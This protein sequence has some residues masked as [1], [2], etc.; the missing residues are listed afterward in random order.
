MIAIRHLVAGCV[1]LLV[2]GA[3]TGCASPASPTGLPADAS[4]VPTPTV[5]STT[6]LHLP[7]EAYMLTPT[8]SVRRD[9]VESVAVSA[10]MRRFGFRVPAGVMPGHGGN[11]G[12]SYSVMYRRYGVT[13]ADS[14]RVWGYHLP[15]P[16]ANGAG[17]GATRK[18]HLP[19]AERAV[20]TGT[21]PKGKAITRYAGRPV[22]SN[23]CLGEGDAVVG[24]TGS[25]VQG[26][27][28]GP[29]GIVAKLKRDSFSRSQIDHR[30]R[31]V[32]TQWAQCMTGRGYQV[33]DPMHAVKSVTSLSDPSPSRE[34]I[35]Q[36]EVDVACKTRVNLVGVWFA[37]ES[38][39][40]NV[41]I[42]RNRRALSKIRARRD[43]EADTI[44]RLYRRYGGERRAAG[45]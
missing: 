36:A 2:A 5:T 42:A 27:G 33:T 25:G 37:V 6:R 21:D 23:G 4:P 16:A 32:F 24:A 45:S 19:T 18:Q 14:V 44:R 41:A 28:T 30:V 12:R 7:I 9:W 40:Q 13:D 39:F 11:D 8:E 10:C 26:P 15:G 31:A 20:L 1:L 43:A 35:S 3:A 29:G 22:P 17:A 38:Q 34:E